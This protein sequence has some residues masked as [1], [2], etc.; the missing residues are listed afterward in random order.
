MLCM[1]NK[2]LVQQMV[3]GRNT[4]PYG[5]ASVSNTVTRWELGTRQMHP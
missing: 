1:G 3:G 2:S 5:G 4:L